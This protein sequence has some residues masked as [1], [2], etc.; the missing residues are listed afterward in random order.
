MPTHSHNR[1][2]ALRPVLQALMTAVGGGMA[3]AH[4]SHVLFPELIDPIDGNDDSARS[5]LCRI[6][7]GLSP[8]SAELRFRLSQEFNI[9][10]SV[11]S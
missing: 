8:F 9:R 10:L 4:L 7:S 5:K 3:D 11:L 2:Y 1:S 6:I